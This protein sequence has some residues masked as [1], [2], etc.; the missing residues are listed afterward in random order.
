MTFISPQTLF[1]L[2]CSYH[3]LLFSGATELL[4]MMETRAVSV[5]VVP[6][7][8]HQHQ[9]LHQHQ[10]QQQQQPHSILKKPPLPTTTT[11]SQTGPQA[12]T[13]TDLVDGAGVH[14]QA[15][16]GGNGSTGTGSRTAQPPP[17]EFAD[18]V[19]TQCYHPSGSIVGIG[20]ASTLPR[21]PPPPKCPRPDHHHHNGSGGSTGGGHHHQQQ[22]LHGTIRRHAA[23]TSA[24]P[25]CTCSGMVGGATIPVSQQQQQHHTSSA[26]L[27]VDAGVAAKTA[28]VEELHVWQSNRGHRRSS[29]TEI[30][31]LAND[32]TRICDQLRES[33]GGGGGG[34]LFYL[35][36][37]FWKCHVYYIV[38][39]EKT[40]KGILTQTPL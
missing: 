5:G 16:H 10:H 8:Q 28:G 24:L 21:P 29:D 37:Y 9:N 17:A 12:S 20:S 19:A 13:P 32:L 33:S 18:V 31:R 23:A 25:A 35:W 26:S 39:K 22:H 14:L 36:H 3:Y 38:K 4:Q 40:Q 6:H 15:A 11:P 2:M 1:Q 7:H 30:D 34:D 27:A